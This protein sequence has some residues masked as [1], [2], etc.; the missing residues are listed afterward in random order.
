M[1]DLITAD[2]VWRAWELRVHLNTVQNA[3]MVTD[4]LTGKTVDP[5]DITLSFVPATD[6]AERW[7]LAG[8]DVSGMEVDEEGGYPGEEYVRCSFFDPVLGEEGEGK[9]PGWLLCIAKSH[10][11]RLP[12]PPEKGDMK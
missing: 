10:L 6:L 4:P 3:P 2:R 1:S 8:V 9:A 5:V 7:V 12:D 11:A